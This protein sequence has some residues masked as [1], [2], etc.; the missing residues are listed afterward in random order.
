MIKDKSLPPKR[1]GEG[2]SG[3]ADVLAL[4]H[5]SGSLPLCGKR[6][7]PTCPHAHIDICN[8]GGFTEAM[9]VA[10]CCEAHYADR[11][12]HNPLGPVCTAASV[13]MGAVVPNFS[14]LECRQALWS[15]S[16][17]TTGNSSPF[18]LNSK[19][20]RTSCPTDQ[21]LA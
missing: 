11:M 12:P 6:H 2:C 15:N 7:P 20:A 18:R 17:L 3:W 16:A 1:A 8:V 19:M 10:G 9:K 14:W 5:P 21:A 13:H 4:R